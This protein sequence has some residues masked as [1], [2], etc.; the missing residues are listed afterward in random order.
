MRQ[1][2]YLA[3]RLILIL[4]MCRQ[5]ELIQRNNDLEVAKDLWDQGSWHDQFKDSPNIY[6]GNIPKILSEGDIRVIFSQ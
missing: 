1:A 2:E 3:V 6:V 5:T 4:A